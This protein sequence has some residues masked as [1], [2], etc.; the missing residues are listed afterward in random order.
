MERR[1]I[2]KAGMILTGGL[3]GSALYG[4]ENSISKNEE[5]KIKPKQTAVYEIS[6]P[7]PFNY[8]MI[9]KMANLND[10]LKKSKI[11]SFYNSIPYPLAKN[12]EDFQ[13]SRGENRN[14]KSFKDFIKYVNYAKDK[15][16]DFSYT[17]NSP[18]P[19]LESE[20][21]Q[22]EKYLYNLLDKLL[23]SN[24]K[25]LK[26]ANTQL[27][28]IL[29]DKYPEFEISAST[30]FEYRNI[31]QYVN[32]FENYPNI[33]MIDVALDE[34]RNFKFL[35]A[36]KK[37]FPKVKIEL[38]ANESCLYGCPARI[39]HPGGMYCVYDCEK[40]MKKLDFVHI[41]KARIIY[42]WDLPYYSAIGINNFKF[43]LGIRAN[44]QIKKLMFFK[45]YLRMIDNGIGEYTAG[46]FLGEIFKFSHNYNFN[47]KVTLKEAKK[48]F[49][50]INFFI[51]NG[52]KCAY[53]CGIGCRYCYDC[54][55]K[56]KEILS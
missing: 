3:L 16:F 19:F 30:S 10:S 13:P 11:V 9:D 31:E 15:G 4:C 35:K 14:I 34:N 32:L 55:Q 38:M 27:L 2:L 43:M 51:K 1:E 36:L 24:I 44:V 28:S 37:M 49:P 8:E 46:E 56:L 5:L 42:P 50:D 47:K 23:E 25:K 54:A 41:C 26:I 18:K 7:L 20:F 22:N 52:H 45:D 40:V 33:K 39:S 48:Y 53:E 12:L 29:A 21:K 6:S 17:L